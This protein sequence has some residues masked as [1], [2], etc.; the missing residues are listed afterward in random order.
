ML[1]SGNWI[2][3]GKLVVAVFGLIVVGAA[4]G[5]AGASFAPKLT[6]AEHDRTIFGCVSLYT[7]SLRIAYGDGQ[8]NSSERPLNWN[9]DNGAGD[10]QLVSGFEIVDNADLTNRASVRVECPSGYQVIGGGAGLGLPSAVR[11][12]R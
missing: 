3:R 8:C 4:S 9:A 7:G 12:G 2:V 1:W 6:G 10:I 11:S 5:M